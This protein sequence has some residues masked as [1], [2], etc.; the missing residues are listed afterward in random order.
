MTLASTSAQDRRT[1]SE[2]AFSCMIAR[3]RAWMLL[4]E[5]L[6]ELGV[7]PCPLLLVSRSRRFGNLLEGGFPVRRRGA[8]H[9]RDGDCAHAPSSGADGTHL[10]RRRSARTS[11]VATRGVDDDTDGGRPRPAGRPLPARGFRASDRQRRKPS[12]SRA[13]RC[14]FAPAW[15]VSPARRRSSAPGRRRPTLPPTGY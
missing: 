7:V 5:S 15:Q 2:C 11:T 13:C 4:H 6:D 12:V 3:R 1:P 10:V 9:P 8:R 14:G